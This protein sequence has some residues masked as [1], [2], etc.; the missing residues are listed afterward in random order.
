M[1]ASQSKSGS[2]CLVLVR[3]DGYASSCSPRANAPDGIYLGFQ[4]TE[5][6]AIDTYVV[7]PDGYEMMAK[8]SVDGAKSAI[9]VSGNI[10]HFEVKGQ[11]SFT[12]SSSLGAHTKSIGGTNR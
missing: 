4:S 3:S 2:I 7:V 5:S 8:T 11:G 12:L 10:A 9:T 6:S 1:F